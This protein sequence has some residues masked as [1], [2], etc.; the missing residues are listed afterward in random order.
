MWGSQISPRISQ[1]VIAQR[2]LRR[3]AVNICVF[4]GEG[5]TSMGP[6]TA[7]GVDDDLQSGET[8]I[9]HRSNDDEDA[10]RVDVV[11]SV[12]IEGSLRDGSSRLSP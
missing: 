2:I 5:A 7:V 6:Q 11:C 8:S 1:A 4:A 10:A 3:Y 12:V 9:S